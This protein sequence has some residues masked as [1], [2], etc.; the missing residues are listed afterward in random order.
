MEVGIQKL[1]LK[2]L[3]NLRIRTELKIRAGSEDSEV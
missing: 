3:H 2:P 1:P